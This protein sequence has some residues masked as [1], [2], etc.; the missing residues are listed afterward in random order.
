VTPH[1]IHIGIKIDYIGTALSSAHQA[2]E[3]GALPRLL[4]CGYQ[5]EASLEAGSRFP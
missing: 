1:H 4:V 5:V 3:D 2:S